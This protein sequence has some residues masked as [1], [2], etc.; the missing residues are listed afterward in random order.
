VNG[1]LMQTFGDER[2]RASKYYMAELYLA[3]HYV[4]SMVCFSRSCFL[5]CMHTVWTE[6]AHIFHSPFSI[7][8]LF[9]VLIE[10]HSSGFET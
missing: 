7:Q 5:L 8:P 4:H 6:E 1:C 10:H 3:V 2:L 9:F